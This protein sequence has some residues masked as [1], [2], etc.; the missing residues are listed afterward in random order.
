MPKHGMERVIQINQRRLTPRNVVT[1]ER[2]S[3]LKQRQCQISN[4][5]EKVKHYVDTAVSTNI[6]T[7]RTT[8]YAYD[9]LQYYEE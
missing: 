4:Q 5:E 1:S 9:E 3:K 8:E 7:V 6:A 2:K